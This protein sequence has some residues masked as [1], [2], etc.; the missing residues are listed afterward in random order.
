MDW[1]TI[2]SAAMVPVC[3]VICALI[4]Q[5]GTRK[6]AQSERQ[7]AADDM[8]HLLIK[9]H[10]LDKLEYAQFEGKRTIRDTAFMETA[11]DLL[12]KRGE[13]GEMTAAL[14]AYM[15]LPIE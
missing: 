10:V 6:K 9:A 8:I 3:G 15:A 13:N 7:E 2:I 5:G 11:V 14:E 12:H 1:T 4:T